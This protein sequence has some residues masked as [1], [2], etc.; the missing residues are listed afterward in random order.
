MTTA[1]IIIVIIICIP[2]VLALFVPK[3]FRLE[4]SITINKDVPTV[5]NYIKYIK[6]QDN[7]SKWNMTDPNMNKTFTGED[8]T[9]G[10]IYAWDSQVK[11]A[12][13]GAQEIVRM[14]E[15]D[16]TGTELRFERPFK[17]TAHTYMTTEAISPESTK[18]TWGFMEKTNT[19]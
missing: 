11:N 5:F 16:R 6:N 1:I 8:G 18:V 7:Y 13:A 14:V 10:F 12:G 17:N 19:R 4:T 3:E 2:F 15:N 9:V